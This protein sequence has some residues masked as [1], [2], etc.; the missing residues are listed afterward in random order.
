MEKR[1]VLLVGS[2]F[3]L[4]TIVSCVK[5][6]YNEEEDN[7]GED[8]TTTIDE[9]TENAGDHEEASDYIWDSADEQII[10]LNGSSIE[11]NGTGATANGSTLTITSSGTYNIRGTLTNGKIIVDTEDNTTVRL[12]FNEIDVT[13][14]NSA[15]INIESADKVVIILPK[16]TDNYLTDGSSYVFDSSTE[17][18]PN[19]ALFSKSDLS[20]YGEGT[21]TIDANYKDGISSKDGLI[22]ASGNIRIDAVDDGIRGKDYLII[23]EGNIT[24]MAG[25]DGF[26]S[27]NDVNTSKGYISIETGTIN[28]TSGG[29]AIYAYTD[30][31]ISYGTFNIKSGGGSGSDVSSTISA[32]GL[33]AGTSIVIDLGD[34]TINSAD[35][36]IH[37][38]DNIVINDGNYSI[39]SGD[40]GIHTDNTVTINNGEIDIT[41]SYE[42]IEGPYI[43]INDGTI[44]IVA[45]DDATNASKGYGGEA[46]DGSILT[47]NGGYIVLTSGSDG[48]DSNGNIAIT[49]G[50]ILVHGPSSQP[51]VGMD[52][53][54][55]CN[56]S[57]GFLVIS[58]SNSSMTEAPSSSSTQNSVL[59]RLSNS[60]SS[61]TLFH[62]EDVNGNNIV[63]FQPSK[64]Y[65]S[66]IFSSSELT[67][68]SSYYI[69]T[70]GTSTGLETDGLYTGGEYSGG[71]QYESF[72]VSSSV[73]I[74][75]TLNSGGPG[76]GR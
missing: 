7:S 22:I 10:I 20:I 34:F 53:N 63:T 9:E 47:I 48:L 56:V 12:I 13:C 36:A 14:S 29:D 52:V 50:T 68:G 73:T 58:G 65:Y 15:P 62:I 75:G 18:E 6:E 42:G 11:V 39:S 24:V 61:D 2:L 32:K 37:S 74:V 5:M 45:S 25:G 8:N 3:L 26:K 1:N 40:D 64:T 60:K 30:L 28:I 31:L 23:R 17:D 46:N 70:G 55:T 76:G 66:I 21:L 27:D 71:T 33:K 72:T 51:E 16:N 35:D 4:L 19:A 67:R 69:Y 43:Y 59:I 41:K 44:K 38:G 57:G 54:G 49:G